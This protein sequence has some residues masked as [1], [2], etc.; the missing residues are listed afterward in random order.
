[1]T[2]AAADESA[3]DLAA[4]VWGFRL[5]SELDAAQRFGALAPRLRAAG[6]SEAIVGMAEEAA[7]DEQRHAELCRQLVCHF[8]G[9]PPPEPKLALHWKAPPAL[10]GRERLRYE[11]VALCCVTETLSTALLGELVARATDAVCRQA[12]HSILRDEVNHSRLGWAFLAEDA[13]VARDCVGPHLPAMLEA[14]LGD[15]L[16]KQAEESDPRLAELAGLGSLER[17]DRL[18]VVHEVL[19]RVI[20]PGL[21]LYGIDTAL[22][23]RWLD[24]R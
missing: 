6:A 3:R 19:E 12:M 8:G 4:R 18:Q 22:G 15:E 20:F 9:A 17:R 10:E 11:I 5:G 21:E 24:A 7:L 13:R 16:F 1:M 23:R 14:T 2:S